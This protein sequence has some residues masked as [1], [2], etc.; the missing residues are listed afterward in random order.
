M[1]KA[2]DEAHSALSR[3][4][5]DMASFYNT[6]QREAPLYKVRDKVWL[7]GQNVTMTQL[8]KKLDHKWLGL[9]LIKKVISQSAYRLKLPS[10]FS[11][12]TQYF[13]SHY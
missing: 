12:T 5:D 10:S 1:D 9:Y 7:N 11:Q 4:A 8:M 2:T 13:Q 6:H 3:A